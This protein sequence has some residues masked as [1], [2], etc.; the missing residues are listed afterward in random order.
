M[1]S[2]RIG[3]YDFIIKYGLKKDWDLIKRKIKLKSYDIKNSHIQHFLDNYN[4][5]HSMNLILSLEVSEFTGFTEPY[6]EHRQLYDLKD[7]SLYMVILGGG[8]DGIAST[9]YMSETLN[10]IASYLVEHMSDDD[11]VMYRIYKVKLNEEFCL[12][13]DGDYVHNDVELINIMKEMKGD[14]NG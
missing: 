7:K 11:D 14:D 6:V 8:S 2:K 4:R 12:Y 10:G 9:S 1:E 5:K 13:N 3:F